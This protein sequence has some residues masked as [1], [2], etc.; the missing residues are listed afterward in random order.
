MHHSQSE[1]IRYDPP[2]LVLMLPMY[3]V[4]NWFNDLCRLMLRYLLLRRWA[5]W[6][7]VEVV[8]SLCTKNCLDPRVAA[9]FRKVAA[10]LRYSAGGAPPPS[11]AGGAPAPSS[12]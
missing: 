9:S 7:A 12:K 1:L 4:E 10:Q 2:K 8:W 6:N 5:L 11:S 3:D